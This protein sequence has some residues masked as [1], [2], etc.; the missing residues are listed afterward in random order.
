[1]FTD[2]S[3]KIV[4]VFDLEVNHFIKISVVFLLGVSL[5]MLLSLLSV[6]YILARNRCPFPNSQ[7]DQVYSKTLSSLFQ[8]TKR[9]TTLRLLNQQSSHPPPNPGP[10]AP[11]RPGAGAAGGE[12]GGGGDLRRAPRLGS[13]QP[14]RPLRFSFPFPLGFP[15]AARHRLAVTALSVLPIRCA[16][17]RL[18]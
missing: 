17:W 14:R 8:T 18:V 5:S 9:T 6:L 1:M 10:Q 15:P 13:P 3:Q 12:G 4:L 7:H 16:I 11:T 2:N